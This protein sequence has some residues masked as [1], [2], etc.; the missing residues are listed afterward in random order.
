[1][2][3]ELT[4]GRPLSPLTMQVASLPLGLVSTQAPRPIVPVQCSCYFYYRKLL[5]VTMIVDLA[6]NKVRRAWYPFS[7]EHD[8]IEREPKFSEKKGKGF[9][10]ARITFRLSKPGLK[11]SFTWIQSVSSVGCSLLASYVDIHS[12][13][14][15]PD[16]W[17]HPHTIKVSLPP[18]YLW[19]CSCEKKIPTCTTSMFVFRSGGAWEQG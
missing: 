16:L 10:S 12:F 18:F 17:M 2:Q 1:M 14:C 3:Y 4:W 9:K 7:H 8:I 13:L 19:F 15:N 5:A 6:Q 11:G